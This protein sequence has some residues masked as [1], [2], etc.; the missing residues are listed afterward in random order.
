LL[1]LQIIIQQLQSI[2]VSNYENKKNE[3]LQVYLKP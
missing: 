3:G 1:N 2:Q